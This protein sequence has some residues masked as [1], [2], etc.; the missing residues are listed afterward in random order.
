MSF[1]KMMGGRA[2]S[3]TGRA[4]F[5]R[6]APSG[7]GHDSVG[8]SRILQKLTRPDWR[9]ERGCTVRWGSAR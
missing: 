1:V 9:C 8:P 3:G 5:Q 6:C 4:G 7:H 2:G